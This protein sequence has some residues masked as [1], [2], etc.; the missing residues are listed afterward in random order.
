[1][2]TEFSPPKR[3]GILVLGGIS[4]V[5]L[6]FGGYFFYLATQDPSGVDFLLH[7]LLS[8]VIFL[9]LPFLVYRLYALLNAVYI[10]RRDGLM[11]RW[12]LRREDIPLLDIE[13]IRPASELGFRLPQPWLQV[14][15]GIIGNRR[16]PELGRVEFM[17][18]DQQH[19]VLVAT[20]EKVYAITPAE[21]KSFLRTYY[22]ANELGSLTPLE[23]QSVYP[24]LLFGRVWEDRIAR[25]LIL[26]SFGIG[27]VLLI[28]VSIAVPNLENIEWLTPGAKAPAERLLLLPV[29]DGLVWLFN[30]ILG[31]FIYRRG[32]EM[33][34]AS[35]LLWGVAGF[36]GLLLLTSSLLLIL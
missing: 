26:S 36:T 19:M 14:P 1:M 18:A 21:N 17:A 24:T 8:L 12:G 2:Q 34:I 28:V 11:I 6:G 29:L 25:L 31:G 22:Q 33:K 27:L 32:G 3:V 10:L 16:V 7:M 30:L 20:P 23:A 35:Y 5:L 9:P 13:W 4:L 15:G